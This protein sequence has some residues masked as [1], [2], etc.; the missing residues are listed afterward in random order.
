M[1]RGIR[2]GH[3][4]RHHRAGLV[5]CVHEEPRRLHGEDGRRFHAKIKH[6]LVGCR[7]RT[8]GERT[9][10]SRLNAPMKVPADHAFDALV[11]ADQ[12][13]ELVRADLSPISSNGPS[14]VRKGGWCSATIVR[15]P[16][17]SASSRSRWARRAGPE[18]HAAR[19][20][21]PYRR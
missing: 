2:D 7:R 6:E 21:P 17:V 14:N 20:G 19:R 18:R 1:A 12:G 9:G 3:L 11:A 8:H 10:P 15:D 16:A 4:M 5:P 13:G